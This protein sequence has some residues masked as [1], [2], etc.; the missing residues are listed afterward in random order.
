[1]KGSTAMMMVTAKILRWG[2]VGWNDVALG[3][4]QSFI[5]KV[6]VGTHELVVLVVVVV[7]T[8][9]AKLPAVQVR[10]L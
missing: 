1:M 10:Y 3:E 5:V 4:R 9:A 8:E 2:A 6:T 7:A